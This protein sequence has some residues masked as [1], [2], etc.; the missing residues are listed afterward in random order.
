MR[1]QERSCVQAITIGK[2]NLPIFASR[3]KPHIPGEMNLADEV[4]RELRNVHGDQTHGKS[5]PLLLSS[6]VNGTLSSGISVTPYRSSEDPTC[7]RVPNPIIAT[8]GRG[9]SRRG[10]LPFQHAESE[11][12]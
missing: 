6:T 11:H 12:R 1:R 8:L 5:R 3:Y 4:R 2:E 7:H 9:S 10:F